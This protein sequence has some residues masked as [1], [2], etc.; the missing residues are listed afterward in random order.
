MTVFK[1]YTYSEKPSEVIRKKMETKF[2]KVP[3][4]QAFVNLNQGRRLGGL[5]PHQ[6]QNKNKKLN[7][8]SSISLLK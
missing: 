3:T 8:E 5:E 2:L 4:F 6:F 7:N 1:I